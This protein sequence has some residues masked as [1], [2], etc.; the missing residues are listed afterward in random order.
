MKTDL[1]VI[2]ITIVNLFGNWYTAIT[3]YIKYRLHKH[4]L[5]TY[6]HEMKTNLELTHML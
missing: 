5:F 4:I 1:P 2:I 6:F 3:K